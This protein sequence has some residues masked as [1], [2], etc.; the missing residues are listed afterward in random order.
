MSLR[1]VNEHLKLARKNRDEYYIDE[2]VFVKN[3]ILE[4]ADEFFSDLNNPE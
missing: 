3:D 4:E 2:C 1:Y